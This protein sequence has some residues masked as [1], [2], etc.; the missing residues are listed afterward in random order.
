MMSHFEQEIEAALVAGNITKAARIAESALAAGHRNPLVY[1]L[2]AW[3]HAERGE[4]GVA[5]EHLELALQI[6]PNDP[7]IKIGL[8]SLLRK[9]G[10]ID[11]ALLAF[12]VAIKAMP[13]NSSAWLERAYAFEDIGLLDRAAANYRKAS[14]LDPDMVP[15]IAG[16]A[17]ILARQGESVRAREFA[18]VALDREPTNCVATIAVAR[19]DIEEGHIDDAIRN[20]TRLIALEFVPAV[21]RIVA[22]GLLG[23][24]YDRQQEPELA[25]A[26]YASANLLFADIRRPSETS[27]SE[28]LS[29]SDFIES[30]TKAIDRSKA[31]DWL[32]TPSSF[33]VNEPRIHAFLIGYPRS[34]TTLVESILGTAQNVVASEEQA[35]LREA[36]IAFLLSGNGIEDLMHLDGNG[37]LPFR[38]SYWD[39]AKRLG[40]D[41]S[42]RLFVDM[43][44]LKGIKLPLIAKLFPSSRIIVVRRDPRDVVWSCFRQN[45]APSAAAYEFTTLEGAARHYDAL[46]TLMQTCFTKM[47]LNTFELRYETLVWDFDGVTKSLCSFLDIPWTQEL[48]K[49]HEK[50]HLREVTTAS[51]TQVRR[52]LYDGS[53]QWRR[54]EE[55]M[56]PILP[57]LRPWVEKFGYVE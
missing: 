14:L 37:T 10:R 33:Q 52:G 13:E 34:G 16:L 22:F 23:D 1:N 29:Q 24:A 5:R 9:E 56:A 28:P 48:R 35:T 46:M 20:L 19:C 30:I 8:G 25:F 50:L 45:F 42:T 18:R 21:E 41:S 54:F 43:D 47:S 36:D 26:S 11:E 53:N 31:E 39:R 38:K 17:S 7:F 44:P 51:A 27:D 3:E 32:T 4:F 15:P 6:S 49:F 12:D 40:V 57:I 2:V 55:Q